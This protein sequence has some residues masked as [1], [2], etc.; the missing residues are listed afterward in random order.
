MSNWDA[1]PR[2]QQPQGGGWDAYPTVQPNSTAG[3]V[4]RSAGAG[5]A[6]GG[7]NLVGLPGTIKDIATT[8]VGIA[9]DQTVGR[10][11]NRLTEGHWGATTGGRNASNQINALNP[12]SGA[13][14]RS[15]VESQTGQFYQPQTRAGEIAQTAGR[16]VP[17]A[18]VGPAGPLSRLAMVAVPT[19]TEE[20]AAQV[21]RGVAP[22]YEP[23]AR[24]AGG[25]VGGLSALALGRSAER[26]AGQRAVA[27]VAPTREQLRDTARSAYQRADDAGVQ[28]SQAG[29]NRLADEVDRTFLDFGAHPAIQPQA[30]AA[31]R[32]LDGLSAGPASLRDL[33]TARRIA[34]NVG[35]PMNRSERTLGS[36]MVDQIDDFMANPR[37]AEVVAGDAAAGSAALQEARA[38]WAASRRS[39]IVDEA[40][41][42]AEGRT[43]S[44]GSG[45]NIDNALRQQFRHI[46]DTPRLRSGFNADEIQ[47]MEALVNGSVG[48]N[49]ARLAGKFAPTGVVSG[50]AGAALGYQIGGTAGAIAV[51]TAGRVAK[52]FAD[53]GTRQQAEFL[54]DL[55][56]SRPSEASRGPL[57]ALGRDAGQDQLQAMGL[58]ALLLNNAYQQPSFPLAR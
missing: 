45:G 36:R 13:A 54:S 20:A 34:S 16:N 50:G 41:R 2:V 57:A 55:V 30:V 5:L 17:L 8:G 11:A 46:L 24:A 19:G 29:V 22:T 14:L 53:R 38:N 26:V 9:L 10:V 21:A 32:H 25:V 51:P 39:E 44:S 40:I 47:A 15:A 7:I 33:E 56:R 49:A 6:E 27:E 37:A 35:G 4:A 52:F 42:R 58:R 28:F 1:F 18:M 31:L 3:D 12:T 48:Q 23:Y 43:S